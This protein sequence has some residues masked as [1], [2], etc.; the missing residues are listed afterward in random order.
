VIKLFIVFE[1][2]DK[3]SVSLLADA[4]RALRMSAREESKG[5]DEEA[6]TLGLLVL[7]LDHLERFGEE[8]MVSNCANNAEVSMDVDT[9]AK[10]QRTCGECPLILKVVENTQV[11]DR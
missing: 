11:P 5:P 4:L 6:R 2:Q 9:P 1:F 3:L 10:L 7:F 8:A